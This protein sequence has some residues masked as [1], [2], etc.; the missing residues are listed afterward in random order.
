MNINELNEAAKEIMK[1]SK[2]KYLE[3]KIYAVK[4][5]DNGVLLFTADSDTLARCICRD[6]G[7]MGCRYCQHIDRKQ[8]EHDERTGINYV[9]CKLR[10]GTRPA[11]CVCDEFER[12]KR[13]IK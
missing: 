13:R 3:D 12:A 11:N 7:A 10:K 8:S 9:G 6:H 1:V 2:Y 5:A 4:V